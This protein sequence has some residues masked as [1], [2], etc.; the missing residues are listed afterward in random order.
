MSRGDFMDKYIEKQYGQVLIYNTLDVNTKLE[1]K[2]YEDT[3]WLS[4]R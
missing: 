2:F 1:V 4:K 3:V